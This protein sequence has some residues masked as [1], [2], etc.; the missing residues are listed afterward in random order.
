MR[1]LVVEDE[2]DVLGDDVF[3]EFGADEIVFIFVEVFVA[4]LKAYSACHFVQ[5][6][7]LYMIFTGNQQPLLVKLIVVT[8]PKIL[9]LGKADALGR[10][11]GFEVVI[12]NF[13]EAIKLSRLCCARLVPGFA[14]LD[15][16]FWNFGTGKGAA[17]EV[18]AALGLELVEVVVGLLVLDALHAKEGSLVFLE[19]TLGPVGLRPRL[20]LLKHEVCFNTLTCCFSWHGI[21]T[22]IIMVQVLG[23]QWIQVV[24][25]IIYGGVGIILIE[26]E[27]VVGLGVEAEVAG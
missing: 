6:N 26:K 22:L 15:S 5:L 17:H 10:L 14:S 21:V 25:R 16:A 19:G 13:L 23:T 4:E 9:P 11:L 12:N 3:Q 2:N 1:D 20:W 27:G 24:V 8:E 18:Q 7:H